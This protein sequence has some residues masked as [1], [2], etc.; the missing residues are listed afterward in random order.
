MESMVLTVLTLTLKGELMF[1]RGNADRF[2]DYAL[3]SN[4]F[5]FALV[6]VYAFA[7]TERT[8]SHQS[9]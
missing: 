6:D 1:V 4:R 9:S 8:D 7:C 2:A 3:D 5:R